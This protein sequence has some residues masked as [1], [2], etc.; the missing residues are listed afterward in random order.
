MLN[1]LL[2]KNIINKRLTSCWPYLVFLFFGFL[3]Y[4]QTLFFQFVNFD[5]VILISDKTEFFNDVHNIPAIFSSDVFQAGDK[6][7]YRPLLNLSFMI[8]TLSGGGLVV[9][10]LNNILIHI[11]AVCLIYLLLKKL[12]AKPLLSFWLSL[13]FLVHPVLTQAVAWLPG[14]NDSLLT[15]FVL[16]TIF[17]FINFSSQRRLFSLFGYFIFLFCALLTKE[18]AIFLPLLII[19]YF[20]T[21]G[22]K[23]R[24]VAEEK[25]LVIFGSG[26]ICFIWL[27]I[28]QLALGSKSVVINQT[29]LLFFNNLW[30]SLSL[31]IKMGGKMLW[32]F[33]LSVMSFAADMTLLSGLI[34]L[35]VLTISLFLSKQK[36]KDYLWLGILWFLCFFITPFIFSNA[37][38]S[39]E[40]RLYL[41]LVGLI[42][43][44]S[45]IDF[46]KNIDF[47][48]KK[49]KFISA[50]IIL[51]L[52]AVTWHYSLN[53][54][55]PQTFWEASVKE[56]PHS[57]LAHVGLAAI[58]INNLNLV[59]AETELKIAL[60][61]NP[62]TPKVHYNLGAVYQDQQNFTAAK[63]EY[64]TELKLFPNNNVAQAA[65]DNL[66]R[67]QP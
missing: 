36:R 43:V 3:L 2:W 37:T 67:Y 4:G 18:T 27:M 1:L 53:F 63:E 59:A 45:E 9:Y 16:L 22:R 29:L 64:I 57:G 42:I 17:S 6:I 5:D 14:R 62:K 60:S 61:I 54:R 20:L 25:I 40:H 30:S 11:L 48:K 12:T 55:N 58:Y 33:N 49:V 51:S 41:P 52:A 28:R 44:L 47:T 24:L 32:P 13:F 7:Y 66:N 35:I 15:V 56:S 23:D 21:V 31:M 39:L 46:L 34:V 50:I 8:D 26:A 65:L 19:I 38:N 10:H